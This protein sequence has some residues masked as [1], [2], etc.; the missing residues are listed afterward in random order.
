[1][2]MSTIKITQGELLNERQ[3]LSLAPAGRSGGK[4]GW[5]RGG[6]VQAVL[7]VPQEALFDQIKPLSRRVPTGYESDSV[8]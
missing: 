7:A 5:S 3:L 1:M 2:Q 6:A 4:W 8:K